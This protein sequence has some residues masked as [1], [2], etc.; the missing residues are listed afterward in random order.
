V[1][2]R[3]CE[4]ASP[5]LFPLSALKPGNTCAPGAPGRV[6]R[7]PFTSITRKPPFTHEPVS[8]ATIV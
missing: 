5:F 6:V 3:E 4:P 1:L 7:L 2:L 8:P